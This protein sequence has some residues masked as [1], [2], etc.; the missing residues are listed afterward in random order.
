MPLGQ[1]LVAKTTHVLSLFRRRRRQNRV[2]NM[3]RVTSD[4]EI[5]SAFL[6]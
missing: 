4:D 1:I 2:T 3:G 5:D 6:L